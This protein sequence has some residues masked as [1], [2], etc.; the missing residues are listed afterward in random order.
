M[1]SRQC[2]GKRTSDMRRLK[3]KVNPWAKDRNK[4][5]RGVEGAIHDGRCPHQAQAALPT[6]SNVIED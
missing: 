6:D 5:Q 2:L 1:L 4:R 3:R